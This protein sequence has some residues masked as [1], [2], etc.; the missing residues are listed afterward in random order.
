MDTAVQRVGAIC[1]A[2]KVGKPEII[3]L[4]HSGPIAEPQDV[5]SMRERTRGVVRFFGALSVQR[6]P[7]ERAKI[8][9]TR[10]FIGAARKADADIPGEPPRQCAERGDV[11][12]YQ[13]DR[14]EH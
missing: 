5:R 13:A 4:C 6:L 12:G 8:E 14:F 9:N 1:D 3:V 10:R 7:A 11:Y 2:A